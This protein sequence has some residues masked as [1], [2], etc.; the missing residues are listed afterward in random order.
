MNVVNLGDFGKIDFVLPNKFR[1]LSSRLY[2]VAVAQCLSGDSGTAPR[3]ILVVVSFRFHVIVQ[4]LLD[5]VLVFRG[6]SIADG[7]VK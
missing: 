4:P 7:F 1:N 6:R 2:P 3:V 5:E